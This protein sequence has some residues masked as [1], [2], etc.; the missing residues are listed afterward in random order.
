MRLTQEE[1]DRILAKRGLIDLDNRM[2]EVKPVK[3]TGRQRPHHEPGRMNKTEAAYSR[4]LE[5]R[6]HLGEIIRWRFEPIKFRLADKTFYTPDFMVTCVDHIEIHEVKGFMEE[7]ANVKIK[8]AAELNP[9]FLFIVVKKEKDNFTF[10]E[11]L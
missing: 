6:K 2:I 5:A 4:H 7:D 1:L 9:E 11:V 10:R 8:V 3:K